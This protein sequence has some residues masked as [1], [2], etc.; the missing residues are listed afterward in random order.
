[1]SDL[2]D[3]HN[4][5]PLYKIRHSLAHVMAQAVLELRPGSTRG[6]G[7]PIDNGFYYDFV[8]SAPITAEDFPEIEKRMKHIIKQRQKFVYEELPIAEALARLE[9]MGEPYKVQYARELADKHGLTSLSF[10]T[11]GPFVDMCEGPH[12]ES[13][14]DL[15]KGAF[16]LRSAAGAYWRGDE[17]N[18]MMTRLYAWA[19]ASKEELEQHVRRHEEGLKR[20]HKKLG[21]QLDLY[22]IDNDVGKG[23]PLWLPHGTAIRD[24]LEK[25]AKET[26]FRAGY[27]RVATPHVTKE[28]LYHQSGHLLT[29]QRLCTPRCSSKTSMKMA[30]VRALPR[31]PTSLSR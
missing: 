5:D 11:N 7:P 9:E 1:M 26:E 29:T 22:T 13:S 10:Y 8:L 30:T 25:L 17:R 23:L 27:Q 28:N 20:D 19:F 21:P 4:Q 15:P 31:K 14:G 12:V 16:R 24:E 6:F 18:Q 3:R 2:G